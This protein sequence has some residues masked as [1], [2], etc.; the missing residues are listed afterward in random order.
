MEF[1]RVIGYF[2][3]NFPFLSPTKGLGTLGSLLTG[4]SR[5]MDFIGYTVLVLLSMYLTQNKDPFF[6][7]FKRTLS[8][9]QNNLVK[10]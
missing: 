8:I 9:D 7:E 6:L 1:S 5:T 3:C 4:E 2:N 10:K